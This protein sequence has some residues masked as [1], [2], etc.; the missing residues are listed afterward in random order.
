MI[1]N[2]DP[3]NDC[4]VIFNAGAFLDIVQGR[5]VYRN[6]NNAMWNMVNEIC[7]VQIESGTSLVLE[8][9]LDLSRGRLNLSGAASLVK[10]P[11]ADFIGS[12]NIIN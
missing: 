8:Q 9:T 6:V 12:V 5:L 1:G 3:N 7:T 4:N 2:N 10:V 11:G